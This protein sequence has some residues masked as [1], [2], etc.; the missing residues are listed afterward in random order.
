MLITFFDSLI[1]LI[2]FEMLLT[3]FWRI[4]PVFQNTL[5][6]PLLNSFSII[7]LYGVKTVEKGKKCRHETSQLKIFRC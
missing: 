3:S 2:K 6:K 5:P 7:T 1:L 4:F